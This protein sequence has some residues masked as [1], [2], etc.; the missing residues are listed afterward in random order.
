MKKFSYNKE[1]NQ[2][3]I[4]KLRE[5]WTVRRGKKHSVLIAPNNRR[6][7]FPSTPSD[8]RAYQNFLHHL[9]FIYN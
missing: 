7:A 2:L 8:Y 5:G 6:I 4:T 1:V 9:K 3:V